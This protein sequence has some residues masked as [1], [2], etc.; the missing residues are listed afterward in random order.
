MV[1]YHCGYSLHPNWGG[2][3]TGYAR[4]TVDGQAVCFACCGELDR[5]ALR[6]VAPWMGYHV[7]VKGSWGTVSNWPGTFTTP[8]VVVSTAPWNWDRRLV[9]A[10]VAFIGPDGA[11]WTGK[12]V[13][14]AT[15]SGQAVT[16]HR[17]SSAWGRR[18]PADM[19]YLRRRA[20]AAS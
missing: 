18:N 16:F 4:R 5:D 6:G 20:T 3:S 19:L 17:R 10:T 1:C 8:S 2:I 12:H 14:G 7:D 11:V 13:T 15:Y 9:V